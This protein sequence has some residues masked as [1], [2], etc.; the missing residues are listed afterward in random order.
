LEVFSNPDYLE[1]KRRAAAEALGRLGAITL[2]IEKLSAPDPLTRMLAA[3]SLGQIGDPSAIQPLIERLSDTNEDESVR[4]AAAISLGNFREPAATSALFE[5]LW[6]RSSLPGIEFVASPVLRAIGDPNITERVIEKLSDRNPFVRGRAAEV[7]GLLKDFRATQTMIELIPSAEYNFKCSLISALGE[8]GDP[9]AVPILFEMMDGTSSGS[10]AISAYSA[11]SQIQ[12]PRIVPGLLERLS[13]P[14]VRL[15]AY[16]ADCL[17][18]IRAQNAVPALIEGLSD[19]N[20]SVRANAAE[21]LGRI[22]DPSALPALRERL[23]DRNY[24]VR[25]VADCAIKNINYVGDANYR[26]PEFI[27]CTMQAIYH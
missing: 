5:A 19:E 11:L 17:G 27:G 8:I 9:R 3:E 23:S 1:G 2:V 20:S 18:K 25:T 21:A 10:V 22:M 12:D 7:L 26:D 4:R 6:E 14:N 16:A 13:S 15:R 24:R